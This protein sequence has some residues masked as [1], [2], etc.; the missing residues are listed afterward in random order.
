MKVWIIYYDLT[1]T[2]FD[3]LETIRN[4]M[5]N[6]LKLK[7]IKSL[8][9]SIKEVDLDEN[10]RLNL[11]APCWTEDRRHYPTRAGGAPSQAAMQSIKFYEVQL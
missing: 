10:E 1:L 4:I 3:G 8:G 2:I 9:I 6:R 5:H 11:L 7:L